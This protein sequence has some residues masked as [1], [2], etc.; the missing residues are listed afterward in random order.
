MGLQV[1]I[2]LLLFGGLQGVMLALF[3]IY[4]KLYNTAYVYLLLYLG[5]ILLQLTL[6]VMNKLWLMDHWPVLYNMSHYLPLL[7][8][9][10]VY[11][12][13]KQCQINSR[14][15]HVVASLND[16]ILNGLEQFLT[17][18]LEDFVVDFR[19]DFPLGVKGQ[20]ADDYK[21]NITC[22]EVE[23]IMG[24]KSQSKSP[25]SPSSTPKYEMK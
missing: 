19:I 18:K 24:I 20:I 7:Y 6:K 21:S 13:V 22:G 14:E 15:C 9:P 2:F 1:N 5:T 8:G 3:L 12:F 25:L 11:L 17:T 16:K 4:K 23:H 10:L